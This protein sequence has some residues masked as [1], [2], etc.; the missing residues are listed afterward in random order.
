M[1]HG[2]SVFNSSSLTVKSSLGIFSEIKN[3]VLVIYNL[4]DRS[5]ESF[6]EDLRFSC[7][8]SNLNFRLSGNVLGDNSWLKFD[9]FGLTLLGLLR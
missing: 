2:V 9:F 7:N 5:S 4:S 6:G 1:G 3:G 8:S